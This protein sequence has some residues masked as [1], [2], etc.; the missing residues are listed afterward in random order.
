MNDTM[1]SHHFEEIKKLK[2][3]T[4]VYLK[5]LKGLTMDYVWLFKLP[6]LKSVIIYELTNPEPLLY[7]GY[8]TYN[9]RITEQNYFHMEFLMENMK[10]VRRIRMNKYSAPHVLPV[11]W[12]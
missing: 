11:E 3:G 4:I 9:Y 7:L 6:G 12:T 2:S 1:Y 8:K 10:V 5:P